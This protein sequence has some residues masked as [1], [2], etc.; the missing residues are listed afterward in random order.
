[1]FDPKTDGIEFYEIF[2]NVDCNDCGLMISPPEP[3]LEW[4][5]NYKS[6]YQGLK[7]TFHHESCFEKHLPLELKKAAPQMELFS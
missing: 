3:V 6:A 5:H 7:I 2:F 4:W 1:M